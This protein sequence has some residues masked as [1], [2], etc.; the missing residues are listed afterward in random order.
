MVAVDEEGGR[1]MRIQQGVAPLPSQYQLGGSGPYG[2]NFRLQYDNGIGDGYTPHSKILKFTTHSGEAS[3]QGT[4]STTD[5]RNALGQLI[6]AGKRKRGPTEH[7][8]ARSD[9]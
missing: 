7:H 5:D 3:I 1:V 8:Q 6:K 9:G 2:D 4:S